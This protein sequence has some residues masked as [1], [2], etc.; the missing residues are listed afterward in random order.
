[1]SDAV[2]A[3]VLAAGQSRRYGNDKRLA[4][5]PCGTS[6][7]QAV[8]N[9]AAMAVKNITLVVKPGEASYF[10]SQ[11]RLPL[12]RV[13]EA[14]DCERGMGVTI[15]N[16]LEYIE[17][18]KL[19]IALADMPFVQVST[20]NQVCAALREHEI[21]V[22][23]FQGQRGHPVGFQRQYFSELAELDGDSGG[24]SILK[25]HA[26]KVFELPVDDPGVL[27]DIDTEADLSSLMVDAQSSEVLVPAP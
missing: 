15:S 17:A 25:R 2:Q 23:T 5:L 3:L 27:Y 22:P 1:M 11:A 9:N 26:D 4:C 18:D 6:L 7:W 20:F 10:Q 16:S 21:V 8:L 14:P 12:L 24:R 13:I 19:I